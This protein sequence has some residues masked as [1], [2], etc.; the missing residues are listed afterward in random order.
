LEVAECFTTHGSH[1]K[2]LKIMGRG[3][4]VFI[5]I[6]I[7]YFVGV[8]HCTCIPSFPPSRVI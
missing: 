8:R 6:Y 5:Y 4:W 7:E 3:R 2:R 1:L